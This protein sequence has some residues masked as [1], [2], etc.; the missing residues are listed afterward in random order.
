MPNPDNAP[1]KIT[2]QFVLS[3]E[4]RFSFDIAFD[5]VSI[6]NTNSPT[7]KP[8]YWTRLDVA[9]CPHCPL[10]EA[11]SPHC[12][13]ALNLVGVI[14]YS[15][16][17]ASYEEA[18]VTVITGERT[19]TATLASQKA[20]SSLIGLIMATS[21]CPHMAFLK[22]MARFHLPFSTLL[23]TIYR[24]TS[25]YML[26]QYFNIKNQKKIDL[27]FEGLKTAYQNIHE[28]NKAMKSRIKVTCQEDASV[29]ALVILD[30][31]T[32]LLPGSIE[33]DLKKIRHLFV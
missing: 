27:E 13:I 3:D 5:P 30:A 19:Y 22:P 21:D 23:D 18:H 31:F 1:I 4:T 9:K 26:S 15:S 33:K 2:Y 11:T 10:N 8:P 14:K 6:L 17:I 32:S 16:I 20:F 12:P 25:M 29:N 28:L 7:T 24:A